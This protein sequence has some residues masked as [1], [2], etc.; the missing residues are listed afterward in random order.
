ML[1]I[2]ER[3]MVAIEQRH[4]RLSEALSE[5]ENPSFLLKIHT[6]IVVMHIVCSLKW[7][8]NLKELSE[9]ASLYSNMEGCD[10]WIS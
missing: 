2:V 10:L 6:R 7:T 8:T 4:A 9:S 5:V 3:G 1:P